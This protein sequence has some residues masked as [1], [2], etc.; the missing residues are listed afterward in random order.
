MVRKTEV[1]CDMCGVA[2]D[3][4]DLASFSIV[5]IPSTGVNTWLGWWDIEG[6]FC[7]FPCGITHLRQHQEEQESC[8]RE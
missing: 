2:I 5:R 3:P 7:S 8:R 4:L 1:E 6:D